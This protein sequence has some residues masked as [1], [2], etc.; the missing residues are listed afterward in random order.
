MGQEGGKTHNL[1]ISP[2]AGKSDKRQGRAPWTC[3]MADDGLGLSV[4]H[5]RF[6][7]SGPN[8]VGG[9]EKQE[10]PLALYPSHLEEASGM[11]QREHRGCGYLREWVT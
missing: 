6:P 10:K 1:S 11:T 4:T 5:R 9:K 2:S 7:N 3:Q 8:I